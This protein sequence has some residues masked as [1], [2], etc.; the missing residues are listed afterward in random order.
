MAYFAAQQGADFK[1]LLDVSGHRE[2]DLGKEHY[3]VSDDAYNRM[4]EEAVAQTGDS[5]FGLHFGES[6]SLS[7]AGLIIQITQTSETVKQALE[8]CCQFANLGCSVLP[9]TLLEESEYYKVS[10]KPDP[11]WEQNSAVAL[12]HTVDGVL[13]FTLREFHSLTHQKKRPLAIHLPFSIPERLAEYQRVYACPLIYGKTEIAILFRKEHIEA[14]VVTADYSLLKILVAHAQERSVQLQENRGFSVS[15][16][17]AVLNLM[18]PSFPPLNQ[19]ANHLNLSARTLQR[20]LKEEQL[21]YKLL[22]DDLRQDF[23]LSYLKR[24]ELSIGEVAYLLGY[25]DNS[26][27][28]RSF[29]RWMGCSPQEYRL[30]NTPS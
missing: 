29:K 2:E 12:R 17:Q 4:V 3:Q 19:V 9:M 6:Q 8:F 30:Q 27:F 21:T 20:R 28:T 14:K 24:A 18:Q 7:A 22:V 5:C 26:A 23:A 11:L 15:V 25:G 13:A 16:K 10:L 1:A